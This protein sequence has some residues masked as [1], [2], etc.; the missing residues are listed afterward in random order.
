MRT[1][2]TK[3]TEFYN[4]IKIWGLVSFIPVI[5]AVSPLAGYFFGEYLK[6]KFGLPPYVSI[7][8]LALGFIAGAKEVVRIL[9]IISTLDKK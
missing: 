2:K 4:L 5:L 1:T 8:L 6:K 3:K 7:A 9:G